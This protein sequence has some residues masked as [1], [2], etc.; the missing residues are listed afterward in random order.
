MRIPRFILV[1]LGFIS[2]LTVPA[3]AAN[4]SLQFAGSTSLGGGLTRFD[5]TLVLTNP[6]VQLDDLTL[7]TIYDLPRVSL[8]SLLASAANPTDWTVAT[9]TVGLTPFGIFVPDSV[10]P[11]ITWTRTSPTPVTGPLMLPGFSITTNLTWRT[12]AI[13]STFASFSDGAEPEVAGHGTVLVPAAV[14]EP[15]TA[16][17]VCLGILVYALYL[18]SARSPVVRSVR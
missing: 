10:L 14:P 9:S 12:T 3:P 15:S 1:N 5:Y 18:R 16:L 11:N 2:L 8:S 17:L 4:I 7:V 13:Y 6:F